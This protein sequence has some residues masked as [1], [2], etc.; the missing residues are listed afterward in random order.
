M[1]AHWHT[2]G[3]TDALVKKNKYILKKNEVRRCSKIAM[4]TLRTG[5]FYI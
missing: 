3:G 1:H 4:E 2:V 5:T